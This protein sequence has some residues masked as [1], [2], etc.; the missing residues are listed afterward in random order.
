[1]ILQK[2]K[3]Y[4]ANADKITNLWMVQRRRNY[5]TNARKNTNP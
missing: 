2:R 5:F 4:H 3:N 1:M